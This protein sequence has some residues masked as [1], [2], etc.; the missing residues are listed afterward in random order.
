VDHS[1]LLRTL[2]ELGLPEKAA[3]VYLSLLGKRRM[4]ISDIS[5]ETGVKR[6]TCYEHLD[7]LLSKDFV[8]RIPVGK[9]MF[10]AALEP[11]KILGEFKKKAAHFEEKVAEMQQIHS[12]AVQKPNVTFYEGKR[13]IK[14]IYEELFQTVGDVRSIFPASTFFENFTTQDYEDFDK[15]LTTHVL[16][17]RDL[18]IA[19][20]FYKR[21][22]EIRDKNGS[23]NKVGKKLPRWFTSNVNVLIFSDKV[24]LI[25]LSDLSATVIQ[26]EDIAE[27]FKNMHDF[28][29]K[30]V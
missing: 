1:S 16:K 15:Q 6:A 27:L 28:M 10:Y 7:L 11:R 18:F 29:W 2:Q 22:R 4:T 20:K 12:A 13:E 5:R 25:S 9:R 30:S 21:V 3:L 24:A 23:S 8:V 17:S 19:D 26:N 14:N